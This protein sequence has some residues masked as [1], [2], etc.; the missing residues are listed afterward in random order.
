MLTWTQLGI[1]RK[2]VGVLNVAGYYQKLLDFIDHAVDVSV[3]EGPAKPE[4]PC[5]CATPS[6]TT[7]VLAWVFEGRRKASSRASQQRA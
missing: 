7:P 2:T 5:V 4:T 6:L 1:H 3:T